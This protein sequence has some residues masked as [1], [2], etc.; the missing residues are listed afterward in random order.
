MLLKGFADVLL[1]KRILLSQKLAQLVRTLWLCC[2]AD[3]YALELG[4]KLLESAALMYG[5]LSELLSAQEN[6][7]IVQ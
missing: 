7:S 3:D 1:H 6:V 2:C 5:D 4:I